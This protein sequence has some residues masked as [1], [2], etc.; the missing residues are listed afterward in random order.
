[1]QCEICGSDIKGNA[2]RVN[3]E[4]SVLDVCG[5]CA[6]YGKPADK[7]SPVSRKM[8]PTERVIVTHKP[9]RDVF[10]KLEGEIIGDYAEAIRKAR[11]SQGLTI[12]ELASKM[13]EK[14]ALIRKIERE[15]LVPE[16]SVRK[17]LEAALGIKLTEKFSSQDQ[18]ASGFIRGTTLGDVAV[19]RKKVK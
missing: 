5:R 11:E 8:L 12:E 4:G 1:M 17:K 9:R 18:R 6:H 7:W 2:I 13:M 15:E 14:A 16:D 10:D 19:I 3:V